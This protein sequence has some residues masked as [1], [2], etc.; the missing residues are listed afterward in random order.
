M[1]FI[2]DTARQY[3]GTDSRTT[4]DVQKSLQV[5]SPVSRNTK[6]SLPL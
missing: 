3:D 4:V 1:S 2:G 6:E 5:S